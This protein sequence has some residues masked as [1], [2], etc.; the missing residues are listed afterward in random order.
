MFSLVFIIAFLF[1]CGLIFLHIHNYF[2]SKYSYTNIFVWKLKKKKVKML[3]TQL[4]STLWHPMVCSPPG[5]SVHGILQARILEWVAI[6]FFRGLSWPRDWIL[7]SCIAGRFFTIW[8]TREAPEICL[9]HHIL[10]FWWLVP[11][12]YWV[13]S[14]SRAETVPCHYSI[15]RIQNSG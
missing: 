1:V 12:P 11:F 14:S 13:V 4:C 9:P 2:I 15:P 7:V 10:I 6:P 5:F 3:V 8:A